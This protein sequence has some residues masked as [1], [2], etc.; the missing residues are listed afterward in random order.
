[1]SLLF[2][3]LILAFTV[4]G[5]NAPLHATDLKSPRETYPDER[6]RSQAA[7][8]ARKVAEFC[9]RQ[10][11]ICRKI[12]N[13]HSNFD[14]RFD[15]CPQSCETREIRCISSACFRW[16]EPDFIIAEKFGAYKCAL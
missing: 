12:C 14:D 3:C 9:F 4:A 7:R 8:T 10:R 1:A 11:V 15:G 5:A 13:M 2:G 16:T 6:P